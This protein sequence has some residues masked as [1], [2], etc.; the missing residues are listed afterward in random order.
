[1]NKFEGL[2][3]VD[4]ETR[5]EDSCCTG[6]ADCQG[7]SDRSTHSSADISYGVH[8]MTTV[9]SQA[10]AW[11]RVFEALGQHNPEFCCTGLTGT[12]SAV[13]EIKRLQSHDS[14][15]HKT[16]QEVYGDEVVFDIGY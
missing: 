14:A 1:M 2:S 5:G 9:M 13:K 16:Q 4:L 3:A 12:E 10:R 8:D 7:H 11:R 6:F 15:T